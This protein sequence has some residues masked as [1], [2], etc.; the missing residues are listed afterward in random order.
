MKAGADHSLRS[1][2]VLKEREEQ[3][4]PMRVYLRVR[5]LNK[6]EVSR[7]SKN[8]IQVHPDDM[9]GTTRMTIDSPYEG[10]YDFSFDQVSSSL[11]YLYRMDSYVVV[12]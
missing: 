7:R 12:N 6:Y 10:Q 2:N 1:V 3:E 5:P 11:V 4:Y 8:C 9:N